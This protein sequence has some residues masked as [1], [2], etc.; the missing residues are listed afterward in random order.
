MSYRPHAQ[1]EEEDPADEGAK[2]EGRDDREGERRALQ[3]H[4]INDTDE[5]RMEGEGE[6]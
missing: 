3:R 6:G 4:M 2:D 5:G 1:S